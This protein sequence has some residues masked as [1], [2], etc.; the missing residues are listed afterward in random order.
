MA[1]GNE[2]IDRETVT[3]TFPEGTSTISVMVN[4]EVPNSKA[5]KVW[6]IF[7]TLVLGAGEAKD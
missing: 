5:A 3:R 4:Y 6:Y 2:A 1:P 7:G